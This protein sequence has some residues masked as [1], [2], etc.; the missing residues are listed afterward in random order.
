MIELSLSLGEPLRDVFGAPLG[1][2]EFLGIL[3]E[4][5]LDRL[6]GIAAYDLEPGGQETRSCSCFASWVI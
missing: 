3:R 6:V 1:V 5:V 4:E 2:L